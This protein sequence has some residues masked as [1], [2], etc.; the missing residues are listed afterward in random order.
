MA[1]AAGVTI[2]TV[3]RAFNRPEL[4][5]RKTR[6]RVIEV[7]G[8]L[9]YRPNALAGSLTTKRTLLMGLVTADIRNPSVASL[10]RGVQ[11]TAYDMRYLCIICSTAAHTDSGVSM[12][13][14]MVWRG[15]D[16][17]ILTSSYG[18]IDG[19]V[20]EFINGQSD[21]AVPLVYVGRHQDLEGVD[22]VTPQGHQ[23][24]VLAV[25]HLIENGH[26]AIAC[27]SGDYTRDV[28]LRRWEAY[29]ETLAASGIPF[30]PALAVRDDTTIEG[31]HRAM[32]AV[33]DAPRRP[34]AVFAVNDLMA[35]GAIQAIREWG[36][37]VPGDISV[38]GFDD[39][40]AANL[41]TPRLTTVAQP[42]YEVGRAAA[43][44]LLRRI[45]DPSPP[46]QS[47]SMDCALVERETVRRIT[48]P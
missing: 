46:Q 35:F 23:G 5:G 3:S 28:A 47:L 43:R 26:R 10:A 2:S 44:M 38:V 34:T 11:D 24:G 21:P 1:T 13:E 7:A 22:F 48:P 45:D 18:G 25:S 14:E 19:K 8:A 41:S 31:G 20:L 16:G 42:S 6:D 4:I 9:N 12:L 29:L 36:L 30:D 15:V 40:P 33:L 27:L 37:S 17:I 39:I 32:R